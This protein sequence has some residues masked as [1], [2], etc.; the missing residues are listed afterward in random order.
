MIDTARLEMRSPR[1]RPDTGDS[2]SVSSAPRR[3]PVD[4]VETEHP[5]FSEIEIVGQEVAYSGPAGILMTKALS[6]RR[7]HMRDGRPNPVVMRDAP[8]RPPEYGTSFTQ[9]HYDGDRRMPFV[10]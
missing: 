6:H 7:P 9:R 4:P 5:F 3:L 8:C 10:S 2:K 1:K